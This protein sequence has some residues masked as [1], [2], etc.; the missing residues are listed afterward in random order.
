[1]G[2]RQVADV[3]AQVALS[4][5]TDFTDLAEFSPATERAGAVDAMLDQVVGWSAALA[6]LRSGRPRNR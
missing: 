3:Q 1:M 6:S 4:L 5:Y 2:E